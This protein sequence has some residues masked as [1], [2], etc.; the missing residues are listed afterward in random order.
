MEICH[1]DPFVITQREHDPKIG[2][3]RVIIVGGEMPTFNVQAGQSSNTEVR[4]ERIEVP[5][6]IIQKEVQ[7]V[8]VEKIIVQ[9][10]LQIERVEIPIVIREVQEVVREVPVIQHEL[11][12]VEVPI[13]VREI[14]YK[15]ISNLVKIALVAQSCALILMSLKMF[16]K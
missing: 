16:F 7:I 1:D 11:K 2:A 4:I 3:K 14:L 10:E 12:L 8:E 5:T 6:I 15:D 9:K 13:V